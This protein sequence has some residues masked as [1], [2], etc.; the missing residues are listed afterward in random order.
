MARILCNHKGCLHWRQ[1]EKPENLP[2]LAPMDWDE[3]FSGECLKEVIGVKVREI[4]S[5]DFHYVIPECRCYARRKDW[6]LHLPYPDAIAQ[7][8]GRELGSQEHSLA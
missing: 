8:G 4:D 7:R 2:G 3:G 6:R 1:L 5:K